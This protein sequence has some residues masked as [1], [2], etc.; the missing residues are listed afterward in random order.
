M[1]RNWLGAVVITFSMVIAWSPRASAQQIPQS[2][3]NEAVQRAEQIR[4]VMNEGKFA[5]AEQQARDAVTRYERMRYPALMAYM[6]RS[7]SEIL[8]MQRRLDEAEQQCLLAIQTL[9][10]PPSN[11]L[12][13]SDVLLELGHVHYHERRLAEAEKEYREALA[14]LE[15]RFGK[16]SSN[17]ANCMV[18]LGNALT[19]AGRTIDGV[20]MYK[21]AITI[22]RQVR[23][24]DAFDLAQVYGNLGLT[25]RMQLQ[26]AEEGEAY[27]LEALRIYTLHG[28]RFGKQS[29]LAGLA[30]CRAH[31][32]DWKKAEEY[33][34]QRKQALVELFGADH[35]QTL[36]DVH[37]A[38]LYFWQ[39]RFPDAI[40]LYLKSLPVCEMIYGANSFEYALRLNV[41]ARCRDL[42]GEDPEAEIVATQAIR[43]LQKIEG[44]WDSLA[45]AYEV[46]GSARSD[47]QRLQEAIDDYRQAIHYGELARSQVSGSDIER[48]QKF[49]HT[50]RNYYI[51]LAWHYLKVGKPAEALQAD[52]RGRSRGLMDQMQMA[53]V[54]FLAGLPA[55][56]A[57]ALNAAKLD[58]GRQVAALEQKLEQLES[59]TN[60]NP[61]QRKARRQELQQELMMAR[62]RLVEADTAIRNASPRY[63]ELISKDFQPVALEKLEAWLSENKYCLLCYA[64]SEQGSY[65]IT[66]GPGERKEPGRLLEVTEEQGKILN[67]PAGRQPN[68]TFAKS[69]NAEGGLLPL[70]AQPNTTAQTTPQLAALWEVLVPEDV[71]QALVRGDFAGLVVIA[72][73]ALST[74]PFETL[75]VQASGGEPTYLLDAGPPILYAPSATILYDLA[76]RPALNFE[77]SKR[78]LLTV[79]DPMYERSAGSAAAVRTRF[80]ALGGRLDRIPATGTESHWV[81][82]VLESAG[83]VAKQLLRE[84]ATEANIRR[85]LANSQIVHLACH[86]LTDDSFGNFFGALAVSPNSRGQRTAVDD[87]FLALPEIFELDLRQAELVILSACETNYGPQLHGEGAWALTRGFL[88]AGSQ[89]VVASDWIVDDKATANLISFYSAYLA[90]AY[91]NG[92]L[93]SY[94]RALQQAKRGVRKME[95]WGSPYYWAPLVLV[96]PN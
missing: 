61:E 84:E 36:D 47:Q 16:Q 38:D 17:A 75:V 22:L 6:R 24:R 29:T 46:R 41:L 42:H 5:D 74:L 44:N 12:I 83:L 69:L 58:A 77:N 23:G 71:R 95:Q 51:N 55:E 39:K 79:G 90:N 35:P 13:Y 57:K 43:M 2:L 93:P 54:N 62:Y 28:N 9:G 7:L 86:G 26:R 4:G 92:G 76:H 68:E 1:T 53:R 3:A 96:G 67:M 52:E 8:R 89:R 73:G 19:D 65:V 88:V 31:A 34:E 81:K 66:Y 14:I 15:R 85:H 78:S 50:L 11:E 72:D 33:L 60:E 40:A 10:A 45:N 32:Q 25:L 27:L 63:R 91:Q 80:G 64:M 56:Q 37:L 82:Q 87:G 94:A 59:S 21:Q 20:A 49:S 18:D 70:L 48:A 30:Q